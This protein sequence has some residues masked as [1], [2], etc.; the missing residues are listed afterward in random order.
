MSRKPPRN[1]LY[2]CAGGR[3]PSPT[4][5]RRRSIR[6][7]SRAPSIARATKMRPTPARMIVRPTEAR[8]AIA[9]NDTMPT[10]KP[11]T[12]AALAYHVAG[13]IGENKNA[14]SGLRER[15]AKAKIPPVAS[16]ASPAEPD[17]PPDAAIP[18]R[19]NIAPPGTRADD[20][21]ARTSSRPVT[22]T[23]APITGRSLA[24]HAL[25]PAALW[26]LT[27]GS[28]AAHR[29]ITARL[30]CPRARVATRPR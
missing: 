27:R 16:V 3:T 10:K 12:I 19:A 17:E 1:G 6:A 5:A 22:R 20:S 8:L 28:P 15:R 26:G 2:G 4:K 24:A 11:A 14:W 18:G 30:R 13:W 7:T 23:A 29:R 25:I 21:P 9:A